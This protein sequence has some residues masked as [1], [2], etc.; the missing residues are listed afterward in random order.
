M[1]STEKIFRRDTTSGHIRSPLSY[2]SFPPLAAQKNFQINCLNNAVYRPVV[3]RH[4]PGVEAFRLKVRNYPFL[5]IIPRN[6]NAANICEF[7]THSF[8]Q[9]RIPLLRYTD[10]SNETSGTD[11]FLLFFGNSP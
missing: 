10:T 3:V 9:A 6:M 2:S 1:K 11:V 7:E 8:V 4:W 5:P